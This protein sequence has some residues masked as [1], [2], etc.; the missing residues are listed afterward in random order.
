MHCCSKSPGMLFG[1]V[2]TSPFCFSVWVGMNRG[3]F[4]FDGSEVSFGNYK[5]AYTYSWWTKS[6]TSWGWSFIPWFTVFYTSQVVVWNFFHLEFGENMLQQKSFWR[7]CHF[8]NQLL[9]RHMSRLEII[10]PAHPQS[11]FDEGSPSF[12]PCQQEA[13]PGD[14]WRSYHGPVLY[15]H[16][17][18]SHLGLQCCYDHSVQQVG[19]RAR[20]CLAHCQLNPSDRHGFALQALILRWSLGSCWFVCNS[21]SLVS[22]RWLEFSTPRRKLGLHDPHLTKVTFFSQLFCE[23]NQQL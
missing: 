5:V 21:I 19:G 13:L 17:F 9:W 10:Q 14:N 16:V 4:G 3:R 12:G 15:K 22:L 18:I 7:R 11:L 1:W 2:D 20:S 23:R 8:G 6:C